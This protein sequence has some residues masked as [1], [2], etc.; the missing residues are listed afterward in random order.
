MITNFEH[1]N[2]AHCETGVVLNMLNFYGVRM[3]EPMIFGISAGY[4]FVYAPL[5]KG[6]RGVPLLGFR[7]FPGTIKKNAFKKLGFKIGTKRY[8]KSQKEKAMREM[9]ELLAAG[10]P[11]GNKVGM[12][13]LP[14]M[15]QEIREH[16]NV[17][18]FCV[19]NK[20]DDEY[21]VSESLYGIKK[22]SSKDLKKVR[23]TEGHFKPRGE[24]YWVKEKPAALPDLS[25]LII[26]GMEKTCRNMLN[27]YSIPMAAYYGVHGIVKL[28]E[29]MRNLEARLGEKA[30]VFLAKI[31]RYLEEL[32]S[33]GAGFRFI[34]SAFLFEAAEI[35]N[36]PKLKDFSIEMNNIGNLWRGF[37]VEGGR[38]LKK[39]NNISYGELADKLLVIATAEKDF[40]TDLKQYIETECRR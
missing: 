25:T 20:E 40:F 2:T 12:F 29:H 27:R 8:F 33:G 17:H 21:T 19:I 35:L 23:F 26:E 37:S 5:S 36:K 4:F 16:W 31:I 9:D 10:T 14:Y 15:P 7:T 22:I 18:Q 1:H 11:V 39:R 28:S 6:D 38:K 32:G 30:P 3:S 24:M 34:Y 13:F